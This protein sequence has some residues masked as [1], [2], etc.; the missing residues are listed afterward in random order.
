MAMSISNYE[1]TADTFTFPHNPNVHDASIGSNYEIQNIDFQ[2]HHIL[3]SGGG[4]P[5]KP[6]ILTGHFDGASKR[7][8]YRSL[9]KHFQQN[10]QLKKLYWETDK[11]YLGVFYEVDRPSYTDQIYKGGKRPEKEPAIDM[12]RIIRRFS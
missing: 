8:N 5:P 1:G 3:V 9:A 11:F 10:A 12:E 2:R 7:A 6:I 4:I